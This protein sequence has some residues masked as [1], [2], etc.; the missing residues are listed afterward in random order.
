LEEKT[1]NEAKK[2]LKNSTSTE[3]Y[4][5]LYEKDTIN[6]K[7]IISKME[8]LQVISNENRKYTNKISQIVGEFGDTLFAS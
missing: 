1:R 4:K 7:S 8:K 2:L 3:C 6:L 5:A